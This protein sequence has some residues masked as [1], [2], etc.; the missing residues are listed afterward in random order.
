MHGHGLEQLLHRDGVVHVAPMEPTGRKCSPSQRNRYPSP[1]EAGRAFATRSSPVAFQY[2]RGANT[3]CYLDFMEAIGCSDDSCGK[4]GLERLSLNRVA[5]NAAV[6]SRWEHELA[7]RQS[8]PVAG[9]FARVMRKS[10]RR[11]TPR[12]VPWNWFWEPMS[13]RTRGAC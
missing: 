9:H 6:E 2:V 10:S 8:P 12:L 3:T 11:V 1:T 13:S 5:R 7:R 4:R